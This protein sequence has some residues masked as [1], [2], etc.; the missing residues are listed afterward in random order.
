VN[1]A[2]EVEV[3][4]TPAGSG[5]R[6]ELEHRGWEKAGDRAMWLH[7]RYAEGWPSVLGHYRAKA[8]GKPA[9]GTPKAA[10]FHG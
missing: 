5:T 8:S 6:V 1:T 2:Q 3:R 9:A 7:E 10:S 4:F